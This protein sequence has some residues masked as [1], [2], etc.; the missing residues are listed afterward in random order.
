MVMKLSDYERKS[1]QRWIADDLNVRLLSQ[2]SKMNKDIRNIIIAE[3]IVAL[4]GISTYLYLTF[5]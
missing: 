5:N 4:F 1:E 3:I 2:I